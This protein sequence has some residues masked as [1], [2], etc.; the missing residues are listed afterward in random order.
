MALNNLRERALVSP[1]LGRLRRIEQANRIAGRNY[2]AQPYPGKITLVR[3]EEFSAL[4]RKDGHL[5]WADLALKGLDCAIIPG[6][7]LG[8]FEE[9]AV[10]T[11]SDKLAECL[12][13]AQSG[14][15]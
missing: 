6:T 2:S 1:D 13:E 7:H 11:L 9:P 3:S 8:M 12:H 10:R 4:S 14:G 15:A 5:R